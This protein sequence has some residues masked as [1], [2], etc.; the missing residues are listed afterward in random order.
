LLHQGSYTFIVTN[1]YGT[2]ASFP[3]TLHVQGLAYPQLVDGGQ[4]NAL[5]SFNALSNQTYSVLWRE[6]LDVG[7]W[8]KLADVNAQP[9]ARVETILDP[10][11][12]ADGRLYQI[13]TPQEAGPI[14][15]MPAIL[16]SPKSVV[17]SIGDQVTFRVF[18]VGDGPLAYQWT[19]NGNVI[20]AVTVS[21]LVITN[22][23]LTNIGNY[24]VTVTDS[25][26]S[27]TSDPVHLSVQPRILMQPQAQTV[28]P[29][30]SVLF[31]VTAEGVEPLTQ[32]TPLSFSQICKAPIP[33]V[34]PYPFRT[35]CPGAGLV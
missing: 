1:G 9:L 20:P 30:E 25:N 34:M 23:Q 11:P 13:V 21:N 8:A 28:R 27:L 7:R 31:N 33:V 3:A 26:A 6:S 12:R 24:A 29:G 35:N 18:A 22:V 16:T 14:N 17:A 19:F 5:L 15:P 2:P 10:L 32:Q 4:T